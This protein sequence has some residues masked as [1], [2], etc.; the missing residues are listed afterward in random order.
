ME[1]EEN[2]ETDFDFVQYLRD[3]FDEIRYKIARYKL[4][5][6]DI[7]VNAKTGEIKDGNNKVVGNIRD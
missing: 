3:L 7:Y 5:Y 4:I 2:L 1:S 6:G